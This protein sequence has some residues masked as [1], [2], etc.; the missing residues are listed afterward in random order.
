MIYNSLF[1]AIS[2]AYPQ[3]IHSLSAAYPQLIR[4]LSTGIRQHPIMTTFY[5]NINDFFESDELLKNIINEPRINSLH[6]KIIKDYKDKI[7]GSDE[8]FEDK[9]LSSFDEYV[10]R[11]EHADVY[12][13]I[14]N[15]IIFIYYKSIIELNEY[16]SDINKKRK[17]D[18]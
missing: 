14:C 2:Q 13:D 15:N 18:L 12:D 7:K 17:F 4:S 10:N 6:S 5:D 3:L 16:Y 11:C 8:Y 9:V 1:S